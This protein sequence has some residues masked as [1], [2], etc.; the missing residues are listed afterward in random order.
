M[1]F[2][3]DNNRGEDGCLGPGG[4]GGRRHG[5]LVLQKLA[6]FLKDILP[7]FQTYDISF[8]S[9]TLDRNFGR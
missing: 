2:V 1:L 9:L 6:V 3:S 8:L 4:G 7:E 5:G